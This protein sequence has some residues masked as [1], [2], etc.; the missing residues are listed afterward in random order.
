MEQTPRRG[1]VSKVYRIFI[2][3]RFVITT[4]L[5]GAFDLGLF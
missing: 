5:L 2:L 1:E 3:E 4:W